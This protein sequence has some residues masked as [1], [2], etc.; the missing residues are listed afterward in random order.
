MSWLPVPRSVYDAV[1]QQLTDANARYEALLEKYHALRLQ[2]GA[3]PLPTGR[4]EARPPNPVVE[5]IVAKAG[6]DTLRR[7]HL[8]RFASEQRGLGVADAEIAAAIT[9]G[10]DATEYGIP[11]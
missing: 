10:V 5:A 1:L 6:S 11:G 7:A 9:N 8:S 4:L 2:Y 3:N